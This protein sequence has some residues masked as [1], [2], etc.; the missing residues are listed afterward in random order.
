MDTMFD[1]TIDYVQLDGTEKTDEA[2]NQAVNDNS[3]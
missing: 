3:T 2:E 1:R